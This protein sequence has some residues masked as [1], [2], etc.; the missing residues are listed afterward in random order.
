M[1]Q[2]FARYCDEV[3]FMRFGIALKLK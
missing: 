1:N 3:I 2:S